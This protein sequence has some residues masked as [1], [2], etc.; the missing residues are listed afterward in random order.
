MHEQEKPTPAAD[1]HAKTGNDLFVEG[2][3]IASP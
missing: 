1:G 3:L 2:R